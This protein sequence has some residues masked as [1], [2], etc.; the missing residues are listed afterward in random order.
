MFGNLPITR[1]LLTGG[2]LLRR[3]AQRPWKK[4]YNLKTYRFI[5]GEK[6]AFESDFIFT[7]IPKS[8]QQLME[9]RN[10]SV[11]FVYSDYLEELTETLGPSSKNKV[12][13]V[14]N[15]D[16][17]FTEGDR[18]KFENY[19]TA[20][21]QNLDAESS[22]SLRVMPIGL[23]NPWRRRNGNPR[24][25]R[26]GTRAGKNK[27]DKILI[28]PLSKTHS[29]RD[30]IHSLSPSDE[31]TLRLNRISPVRYRKLMESHLFVGAPRGNGIDTHRFWESLY[32]AS[33]PVVTPSKWHENIKSLGIP[34]REIQS[35]GNSELS[36]LVHESPFPPLDPPNIPQLWWDWWK[37]EIEEAV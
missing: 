23:E 15:S 1:K 20:F 11:I 3:E 14:G 21:V 7:Q 27:K 19:R 33:I 13:L 31:I 34:S 22:A 25:Y 6:F 9:L 37:N 12:I 8:S 26:Q 5:C 2:E 18:Q 24:L 16:R 17:D 36:R 10:S 35:W 28:G 29:E 4:N 32:R 30:F